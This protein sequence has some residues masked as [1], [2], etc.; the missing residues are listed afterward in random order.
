MIELVRT[1]YYESSK[2]SDIIN[3]ISI[4][5]QSNHLQLARGQKIPRSWF[6]E[7]NVYPNQVFS[8]LGNDIAFSEIVYLVSQFQEK[9]ESQNV[10][11]VNPQMI[12]DTIF[13]V[14]SYHEISN[15]TLFIPIA[16]FVLWHTEWANTSPIRLDFGTGVSSIGDTPLRI[17]WSNKYNDFQDI[18]FVERNSSTWMSK[19]TLDRRLEINY[20]RSEDGE[21]IDL[22]LK[23]V[24]S[25]DIH[26]PERIVILSPTN[27]PER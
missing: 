15:I 4:G 22:F 2:I 19:N 13:N 21:N 10:D 27:L 18:I 23:T 6:T 1:T 16:Y 7:T 25:L 3:T 8:Q 9:I 5:E 17:I 26:N 20:N 14:S 12:S 11:T 24:F